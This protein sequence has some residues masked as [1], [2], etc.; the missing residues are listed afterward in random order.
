M[1]V[2]SYITINE[3]HTGTG[4]V[5]ATAMSSENRLHPHHADPS[6]RMYVRVCVY[7]YSCP[8]R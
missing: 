1:R 5:T 3:I 8:A 7:N 4:P 6:R 2:P